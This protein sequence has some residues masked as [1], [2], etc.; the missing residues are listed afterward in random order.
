MGQDARRS[1]PRTAMGGLSGLKYIIGWGGAQVC[2][3]VRYG[4]AGLHSCQ[5]R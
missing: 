3:Q 4:E 1:H 2:T 5:L